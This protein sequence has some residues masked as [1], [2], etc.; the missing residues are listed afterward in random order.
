MLLNFIKLA[1]WQISGVSIGWMKIFPGGKFPGVN[2]P[3]GSFPGC[4]LSGWQFFGW[5]FS[6]VG[7]VRVPIFRVAVFLGGNCPGGTY[8]WWEFPLVE[9]FRVGIVWW[10]SSGLQFSGWEFSF[11]RKISCQTFHKKTILLNFVNL[12]LVFCQRLQFVSVLKYL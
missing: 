11:Y 8:P 10:E 6:L 12:Y 9:V 3:G 2:L 7:V 4:E 1:G 5:E